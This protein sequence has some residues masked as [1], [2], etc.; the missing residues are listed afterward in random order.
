MTRSPV[1]RPVMDLSPEL[2]QSRSTTRHHFG[3]TCALVDQSP[4]LGQSLFTA[5]HHSGATYASANSGVG[6]GS[7]HAQVTMLD[8]GHALMM[9]IQ[10]RTTRKLL[11]LVAEI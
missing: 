9:G 6:Q 10:Q 8:S 11:V 3:A 4:K 2:G 1:V 5:Q 7:L